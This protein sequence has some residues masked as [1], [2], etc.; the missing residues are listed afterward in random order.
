MYALYAD[1]VGVYWVDDSAVAYADEVQDKP[2]A[3]G[4]FFVAGSDD[5][6]A[7]W[8]EDFVEGLET[9]LVHSLW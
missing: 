3:N 1:L 6:Y 2:I 7:C 5:G 4:A 9:Q 8:V